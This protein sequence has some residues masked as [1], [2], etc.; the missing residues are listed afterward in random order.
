[1]PKNFEHFIQLN[2]ELAKVWP[3]ITEVKEPLEDAD[4]WKDKPNKFDHLER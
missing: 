2:A 3:S 1:V 4:E